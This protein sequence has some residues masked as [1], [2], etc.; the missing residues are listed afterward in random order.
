MSF[1]RE[2]LSERRQT[3]LAALTAL[4]ELLDGAA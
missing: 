3:R 4:G 2:L 1:R